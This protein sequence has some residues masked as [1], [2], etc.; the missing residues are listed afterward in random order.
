MSNGRRIR[1]H[2]F[3]DVTSIRFITDEELAKFKK[4]ELLKPYFEQKEGN[5][6]IG[7]Q[8]AYDGKAFT[9]SSLYR[10]YL[11][12]Y[13]RKHPLILL[14]HYFAVRHLQPTENGLPLEIFVYVAEKVGPKY[15]A[16]QADI[17]DHVFAIASEFGIRIVQTPTSHDYRK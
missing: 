9:N 14:E 2:F 8:A 17:F 5:L 4:I 7:L 1:R 11:E 6:S 10:A 13:L 16:I 12:A 3:I 15:E